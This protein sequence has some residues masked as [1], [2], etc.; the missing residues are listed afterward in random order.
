[1]TFLNNSSGSQDNV[2]DNG[3]SMPQLAA[4]APV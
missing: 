3:D 2:K 1:M 4:R